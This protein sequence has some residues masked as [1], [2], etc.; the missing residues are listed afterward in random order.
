MNR[1]FR[2]ASRTIATAAVLSSAFAGAD[3]SVA[4]AA[5]QVRCASTAAPNES[6]ELFTSEGCSSC[7][8]AD[9]WMQSLSKDRRLWKTVFPMAWHV[10]Y[11]ND[12]GWVDS[13]SSREAT[14]RQ[15]SYVRAWGHGGAYTPEF[16]RNGREWRTWSASETMPES[17]K[18]PDV[19]ILR[20]TGSIQSGF[21]MSFQPVTSMNG[22]WD[23][24]LVLIQSGVSHQ[25]LRGENAGRRLQH[26]FAVRV[27]GSGAMRRVSEGAVEGSWT[28]T[29]RPGVGG[30]NG[31]DSATEIAV[32]GWVSRSGDP[33]PVQITGAP[34]PR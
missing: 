24:H 26:G 21:A 6:L 4:I 7:P 33:A 23:A 34:L 16:V 30:L 20:V 12:L 19:G 14:S 18:R 31:L 5:V 2:C 15:E 28:A 25:V 32:V 8:P 13:L 17:T 1:I 29:L 27:V 9:R 10:D 3:Q 22:P 11:W